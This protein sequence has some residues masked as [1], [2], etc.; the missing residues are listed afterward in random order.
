MFDANFLFV[1]LFILPDSR[2]DL[3]C[4]N[5]VTVSSIPAEPAHG[6]YTCDLH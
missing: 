6:D 5:S 1:L 3:V 2:V 4:D